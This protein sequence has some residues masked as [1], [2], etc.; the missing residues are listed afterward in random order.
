MVRDDEIKRLVK[1]ANA[2][3]CKV[4]FKRKNKV[5]KLNE[6]YAACDSD[7]N[8]ITVYKYKDTSK[9]FIVLNLI[10]ELAHYIG[11]VRNGRKNS[12]TNDYYHARAYNE[13]YPPPYVNYYIFCSELKDM[14][15]WDE[16]IHTCDIKIPKKRI[17]LQK[18][19]DLLAYETIFLFGEERTEEH[20]DYFEKLI[21]RIH[22]C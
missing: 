4:V 14:K 12:K 9:I 3:G 2:M 5:A 11:F 10:H 15:Y 7:T 16:I 19:L 18:D 22:K 20:V 6:A 1:Y 21:K 8:T 13:K 17:E